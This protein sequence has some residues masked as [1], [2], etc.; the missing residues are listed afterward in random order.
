[1]GTGQAS[2]RRGQKEGASPFQAR[3]RPG[4]AVVPA[5]IN[6]HPEWAYWY[7]DEGNPESAVRR[8]DINRDVFACI[9]I[10]PRMNRYR[11]KKA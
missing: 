9:D 8:K 7:L 2:D 4:D 11:C 1:M 6:G 10:E 5:A 3:F